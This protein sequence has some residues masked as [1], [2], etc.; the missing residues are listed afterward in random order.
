MAFAKYRHALPQMSNQRML[1]DDGVETPLIFHD[2]LELPLFSAF[3]LLRT[4]VGRRALWR[5]YE[6]YI[7][8]AREQNA[9][10][11]LDSATWRASE[12]WGDQLD[13]DAAELAEANRSAV[14]MLFD[15]REHF[16]GPAPFVISGNIGPIGDG[17][18]AS[19]V[20]TLSEAEA[21]HAT[22][23][24]T[25]AA[26]GVDM[27]SAVTMTHAG[28]AICIARACARHRMPLALSFASDTDGRLPNGQPL[29]DA[30]RAVDAD[31]SGGPSY[32][33]LNC[34]HPDQLRAILEGGGDWTH[35]IRGLCA[36]A[37]R[38]SHAELDEADKRDR[39]DSVELARDYAQLLQ[40]LP[41]LRVFGG[42]SETDQPLSREIG[43]ACLPAYAA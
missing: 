31:S 15:L 4:E 1:T 8:I 12:A 23:V 39:G 36:N 33:M 10:L 34:A 5:Y 3:A 29:G 16:E 14:A 30:I 21:F 13:Y 27:I 7:Q 32:Y 20:R 2:R 6:S 37:S 41:N 11:V 43:H 40:L 38:K 17:Y 24:A 42:R 28:E 26:T 35:R 19:A 22:Q 18:A 9:G 25:F